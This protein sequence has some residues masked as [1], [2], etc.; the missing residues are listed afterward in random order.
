M[1]LD[2]ES[3]TSHLEWTLQNCTRKIYIAYRSDTKKT[4]LVEYRRNR[5]KYDKLLDIFPS[6]LSY[7]ETFK[8]L[9]SLLT[10]AL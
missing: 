2:V 3:Q 1:D 8:K 5:E 7:V 9:V 10:K 4:E 6:L